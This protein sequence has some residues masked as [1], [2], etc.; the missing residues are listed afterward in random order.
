MKLNELKCKNCG[1]KISVPEK[2]ETVT[3]KYCH[4]TFSVDTSYSEGYNYT[5]GV[6]DAQEEKQQKQQQEQMERAKEFMNSSYMS[7]A[8]KFTTIF[9]IIL[10]ILFIVVVAYNVVKI[11]R[12]FSDK[13]DK[14]HNYSETEVRNFNNNFLNYNGTKSGFWVK[15]YL[16]DI[17]DSNKTNKS[18]II[19]VVYND[20]KTS[21]S[22]E[23]INMK[24]SIDE[25]K[26]YEVIVDYDENGFFY[27]MTIEE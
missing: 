8:T 6:L 12:D 20:I 11:S 16:D 26:K 2:T 24:K 9:M 27:L 19:T 22:T 7:K 3:C 5:K 1:A 25:N 21:D 4:T 10:A 23:I 14:V 17:V 15:D 13:K 18:H